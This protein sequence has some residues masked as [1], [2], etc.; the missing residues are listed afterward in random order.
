MCTGGLGRRDRFGSSLGPGHKPLP[1]RWVR[2]K[3]KS[4]R[5]G[6]KRINFITSKITT[7]GTQCRLSVCPPFHPF[8]SGSAFFRSLS[9]FGRRSFCVNKSIYFKG[10]PVLPPPQTFVRRHHRSSHSSSQSSNTDAA[11]GLRSSHD[12]ARIERIDHLDSTPHGSENSSPRAFYNR[13]VGQVVHQEYEARHSSTS[14]RR[15]TQEDLEWILRSSQYVPLDVGDNQ[16]EF[17]RGQIVRITMLEDS[18]PPGNDLLEFPD[19]NESS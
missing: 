6:A 3:A 2:G 12:V 11:H 18:G 1:S 8:P 16:S 9:V 13:L 19:Q 14:L 7:R 10:M 4:C 17:L 5:K 15:W